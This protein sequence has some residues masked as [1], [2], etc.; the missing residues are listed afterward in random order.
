MK[1]SGNTYYMNEFLYRQ[2]LKSFHI[3]GIISN[4][5]AFYDFSQYM[6]PEPIL[7]KT[8]HEELSGYDTYALKI[9]YDPDYDYDNYV[10]H[11]DTGFNFPIIERAFAERVS[12]TDEDTLFHVMQDYRDKAIRAQFTEDVPKRFWEYNEIVKMPD[13]LLEVS[14]F[15]N[16][17][18]EIRYL[19]NEC[20]D[21]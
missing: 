18:E 2:I 3:D 5:M 8:A 17:E 20:W 13:K 14:K 19:W 16:K 9:I 11:R 12:N 7:V 6:M 1:M 21:I 4:D 10:S 15:Y